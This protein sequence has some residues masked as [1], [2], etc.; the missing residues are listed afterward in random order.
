MI[1]FKILYY[2]L[3]LTIDVALLQVLVLLNPEYGMNS[4]DQA[5]QIMVIIDETRELS[6]KITEFNEQYKDISPKKFIENYEDNAPK[7]NDLTFRYC[8]LLMQLHTNL[9]DIILN[10]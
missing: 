10:G 7:L 6:S 3:L 5:Y 9:F 8:E 2:F 1:Y 4:P